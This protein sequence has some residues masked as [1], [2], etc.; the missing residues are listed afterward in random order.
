MLAV[1]E[2]RRSF[3]VSPEVFG[4][5]N[6]MKLLRMIWDQGRG[7]RK[8]GIR[9]VVILI[10]EGFDTVRGRRFF[11][12]GLL[13]YL[14]LLADIGA[15]L[16]L[17]DATS[18]DIEAIA[19][20]LRAAHLKVTVLPSEATSYQATMDGICNADRVQQKKLFVALR[21]HRCGVVICAFDMLARL[22]RLFGPQPTVSELQILRDVHARMDE[23]VGKALS[24]VDE[25]TALLAVIPA[26]SAALQAGAAPQGPEVFAGLPLP[27][28]DAR[29]LGLAP[30]VLGILDSQAGCK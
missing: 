19:T 3:P 30:I 4:G 17:P 20:A 22:E 16:S 10:L 29:S 11:D 28:S 21:R 13:H 24:F 2:G 7:S 1:V 8:V 12:E 25:E 14:P 27:A 15:Q 5:S 18:T 26:R 9:R 6:R 23:N